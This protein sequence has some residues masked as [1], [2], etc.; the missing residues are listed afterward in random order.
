MAFPAPPKGHRKRRPRIRASV[1]SVPVGVE[2]VLVA[3]VFDAG[4]TSLTLTFDR[5]I[6]IAGMVPYQITVLDG[7][8]GLEWGATPSVTQI[9]PA[10]VEIMMIE[11]YAFESVG[12]V[13]NA[14]NETG[15][16]AAVGG[17]SW[18]GCAGLALPFGE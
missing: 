11:L 13:M 7:P 12:V 4:A 14:T 15:I 17:A 6:D 5:A 1:V 16:V 18:A 9:G 10:T 2:P 3:G 8:G